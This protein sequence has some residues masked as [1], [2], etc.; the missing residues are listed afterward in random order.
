MSQNPKAPHQAVISIKIEIM[1]NLPDGKVSGIPVTKS[2]NIFTTIGRDLGQ[3]S[4]NVEKM[5]LSIKESL[6]QCREET[7]ST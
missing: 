5:L 4:H 3:C 2:S 1:E 7:P 6:K